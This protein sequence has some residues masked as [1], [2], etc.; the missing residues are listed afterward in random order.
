MF[1]GE[2]HHTLDDKGRLTIPAK[3]RHELDGGLVVTRGLDQNLVVFSIKE[4]EELSAKVTNLSWGDAKAREFRRRI[5]SG[6]TDLKLDS[7]G[8]ILLPA[9]LREFAG[10]EVDAV[11]S[12]MYNHF[13]I[14]DSEAWESAR[15]QAE[16]ATDH[17]EDLGI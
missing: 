12:G 10:I 7:Q 14:W 3:Y 13:E 2:Y 5:F 17:L 9:Y 4:F 1:L 6:A 8:R 11:I 16:K 15:E